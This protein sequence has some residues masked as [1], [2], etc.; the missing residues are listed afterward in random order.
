MFVPG[1]RPDMLQKALGLAPDAYVP[2]LE[3][4]V[5]ADEK[6]NARSITASFLERLAGAGPLVL[7]RVNSLDT[8][9]MEDDL[10]AVVGPHTF[11]V[12]V[13]KVRSGDDIRHISGILDRLEENTGLRRGR[14]MLV[15]WIE[16]AMGIVNA[17]EICAASPRVFAA[18]FG[19]EDF[20]RDMDIER[21][22]HDA[23]IAYP[24]SAVCI[25]ARAAGVLAMDTP[26]FSFRDSDGLRA[27][28]AAAR[29]FGFRGKFAIHPSQIDPIRE[30]FSPTDR[31]KERAKR[32]IAAFEEAE[33]LGK[34]A[35]SLDGQLIDVPVVERARNLLASA[36]SEGAVASDA[37]GRQ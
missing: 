4:S 24:R 23:E 29:G 13:G 2:D 14:T 32:V 20:T 22:G 31:E 28:S 16:T 8:G 12:S 3:D 6:L 9:L 30:A 5:P 27:V 19:A 26:Y 21:T 35:T 34:G 33:R 25:A 1:N 17:Y 15:P 7:P 36:R 37:R 10:G 11:G 18:A